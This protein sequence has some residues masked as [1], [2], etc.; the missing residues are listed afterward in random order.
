MLALVTKGDGHLWMMKTQIIEATYPPQIPLELCHLC[1]TVVIT[2]GLQKT[3]VLQFCFK[4][5]N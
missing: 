2:T 1:A 3:V 5:K 4:L